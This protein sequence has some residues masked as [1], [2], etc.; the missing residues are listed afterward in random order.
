MALHPLRLP[1]RSSV[2]FQMVVL[3]KRL[4]EAL[5]EPS[6]EPRSVNTAWVQTVWNSM[7]A[8]WVRQFCLGGQEARLQ[9]MARAT[10]AARE[11]L[12]DE[13][14]RQNKVPAMLRSGGD[15][16]ALR[17][18]PDFSAALAKTVTEFF[19]ACYSLLGQS[20]STR[21][22]R[23]RGGRV[24]TLA[25]YKRQFR[26]ANPAKMVCPYCDGDLGTAELDH[27]YCKSRFPLLA[28]SP[29]NLVPICKSC[30]DASIAKGDRLAL[31]P[32]P[33]RSTEDWL[34]PFI[35]PASD[36]VVIRLSGSPRQSVPKL[37]SP[38]ADEQRRLDNHH[39]LLDRPDQK[40][41]SF[42]LSNRWTNAVA[43]HHD[44][45]ITRVKRRLTA[46]NTIDDIIRRQLED[47]QAERGRSPFSIAHAAVCQ[48]ILDRRSEYLEEFTDSNPPT[49][50]T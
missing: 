35:C 3:Q 1:K 29:W 9:T 30:N 22:Y 14:C 20:S 50:A 13:F 6:L 37:H 5:A 42:Y 24:M 31:T 11:A 26:D 32:G 16:R 12:H 25:E 47:H 17:T 15:F 40:T 48:A 45:L 2:I 41:Q 7:D 8:E 34:H 27:Y 33:P 21:G 38:D 44:V 4:L 19:N 43:Q 28:C 49:F 39:W 23:F 36:M 18:L 10:S 46:T